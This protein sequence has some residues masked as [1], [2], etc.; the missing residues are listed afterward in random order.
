MAVNARSPDGV[1]ILL[2]RRAVAPI[3]FHRVRVER[4]R[5]VERQV[6]R[7]HAV[8]VDRRD[9][10]DLQIRRRDVEDRDVDVASAKSPA[11]SVTRAVTR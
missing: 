3:D 7:R 10:R 6:Q 9:R 5:I 2:R 11:A 1:Q 8:L 4:P